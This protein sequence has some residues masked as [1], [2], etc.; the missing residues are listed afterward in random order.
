[1]QLETLV[2]IRDLELETQLRV[3]KRVICD[4]ESM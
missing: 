3:R 2:V 1:M 4:Q